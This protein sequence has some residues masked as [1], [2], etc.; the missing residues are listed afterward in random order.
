MIV[1]EVAN[2]STGEV[3]LGV[4]DLLASRL[5]KEFHRAP[6]R[7][8]RSWRPEHRLVLRCLAYAI[9]LREGRAFVQ[10]YAAL[11]KRRLR[12]VLS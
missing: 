11:R 12:P 5:A 4:T 6:P 1:F 8:V 3:Y 2:E 9:P 10:K 7:A